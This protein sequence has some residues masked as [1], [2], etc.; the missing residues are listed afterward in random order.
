MDQPALA[1]STPAPFP[2]R[3]FDWWLAQVKH[4]GNSARRK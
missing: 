4:V 1:T 3:A 2:R